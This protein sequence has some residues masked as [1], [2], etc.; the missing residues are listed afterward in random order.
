MSYHVIRA[1]KKSSGNFNLTHTMFIMPLITT[2]RWLGKNYRNFKGQLQR[3]RG[4]CDRFT[5]SESSEPESTP[6]SVNR[7]Y[8]IN[9]N[10]KPR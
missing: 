2:S 5:E 7:L 4:T 1:H 10:D 3:L 9:W 6:R 8:K